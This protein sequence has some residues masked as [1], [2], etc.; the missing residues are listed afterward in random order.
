MVYELHGTWGLDALHQKTQI[1]PAQVVGDA[2]RAGKTFGIEGVIA[3]LFVHAATYFVDQGAVTRADEK[4][5]TLLRV[6]F[7]GMGVD[8]G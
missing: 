7:A 8:L 2:R 5:T 3:I 4:A 6:R 1:S